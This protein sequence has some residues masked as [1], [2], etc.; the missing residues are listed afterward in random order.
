MKI[1]NFMRPIVIALV[2][3][4]VTACGDKIDCNSSSV[5]KN[6]IEIVQSHLDNAVWYNQMKIAIK[7][8]PTIENITKVESSS[9][10]NQAQ[11]MAKYSITY[12]EKP[13]S[14]DFNYNLAYLEDKK[15]TEVKVNVGEVQS[16]LTRI[17]MMESPIKNGEEKIYDTNNKLVA[18]R[19]WKKS[20]EDGVQST[21]DRHTGTLIHQY[22]MVDGK[23]NGVEKSWETDG[24]VVNEIEWKNGKANG[25]MYYD[26]SG[27]F[28][29]SLKFPF[30]YK[31]VQLTDGE[32]NG[33]Q[34]TY[35]VSNGVGALIQTENFKNDKLDG[36][37]QKFDSKGN[38]IFQVLYSQGSLV[39]TDALTANSINV[40]IE[41]WINRKKNSGLYTWGSDQD[42]D[43]YFMEEFRTKCESKILP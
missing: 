1:K 12:N 41:G 20:V 30:P 43:K 36:L 24:T 28:L 4:S 11:C 31:V 32:K 17:I 2:V 42:R 7:G 8:D 25:L 35:S 22:N 5:K 6:V 18:V 33:V 27:K 15:D 38:V 21:Y 34:K 16:G 29:T 9:N 26:D 39:L 10:G 19:N 3:I 37:T 40:C 23:K 14:I 13:R